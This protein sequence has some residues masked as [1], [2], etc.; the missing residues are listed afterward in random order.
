MSHK[1]GT[2]LGGIYT[3]EDLRLRSWVDPE[4]DCWRMR[5]AT[6]WVTDR[7]MLVRRAA[8][9]L[10]GANMEGR[11]AIPG[12]LTEN[13]GNPS[14]SKA[15]TQK[16]FMAWMKKEGFFNATSTPKRILAARTKKHVKLDEKKAQEIRESTEK[17]VELAKKYGVRQS[18]ISQIR[19]G[20]TWKPVANSSV[21]YR[22][23][24]A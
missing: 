17:Q 14:H 13:C 18:V 5:S 7:S 4:T 6:V 12:C 9:V 16:Q 10:S 1:K 20:R 21:F 3:V 2:K 24:T 22:K 11:R 8:L 15:V 19:L 23:E